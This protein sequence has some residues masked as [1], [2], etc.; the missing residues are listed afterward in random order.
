MEYTPET[1]VQYVK[2]V[3]P[4]FAT[5]L[6]KL[7]IKT[8]GDLLFLLPRRYEDRTSFQKIREARPGQTVC[9]RGR[10]IALDSKK[11][12][13]TMVI[14]R[15][16]IS[17]GSGSIAL[18]WFNQRWIKQRLEKVDGDIIVYGVVK[19]GNYGFEIQSPEFETIEKDESA[20]NF[21]RVTPIYPLTEG[22]SQKP[23]RKAIKN[24]IEHAAKFVDPLPESFLQKYHLCS[25]KDA[26]RFVHFPENLKDVEIGRRRLI[27]EDFFYLQIAMLKRRTEIGLEKGIAFQI[28]KSEPA[29][30]IESKLHF[31]LTS[32]Q[33][34]VINEIFADMR[35][36]HPMN[37]LLQGD[38]G[39]GKTLVAAAAILAA[40]KNGYQCALMA[41]TEILAEQHFF[42]L[43]AIFESLEVRVGLLVGK[44]SAS[45]KRN[46][47]QQIS[48][49]EVSLVVGTHALIQENVEFA[50]LGLVVVDEQHRFG[51]LQ[52]AALRQKGIT[53]DV[54]VMSATP[55][56]RSLT[57]T[58][59][60]DLSLSVIDEMPIGRKPIKTH[61][62]YP[63]ERAA[64]YDGVKKLVDKGAQVYVVCPLVS[65]SEKL[66]VQAAEEL[67][68]RMKCQVF[69]DYSIGLL[70]G[71]QKSKDKQAVMQLFRSG[72]LQILVSTTV[73]EVGVDVPNATVM[74]IEDANRFGLSQLHQLRGRVGRGSS[75]SY[76]VLIASANTQDAEDRLKVMAETTNGFEIAEADLKIRGP[77][78]MLGTRQS[79]A[80][81]FKVADI[82][83]DGKLLEESRQAAL[84]LLKNDPKLQIKD[85]QLIA[86]QANIELTQLVKT[87]LS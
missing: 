37:R 70:H 50:N 43:Q 46:S 24:A 56:P 66:Q 51:V 57:L 39:S 64:V 62:K 30:E 49:S 25:L 61:W 83:R 55:I 75:Q 78:D 31:S 27:F 7:N 26:L 63:S 53:P 35:E 20:E 33:K 4:A 68:Q 81:D 47:L 77:G 79:G 41:P 74:I 28:K 72:E 42:N 85:H 69:Q 17:D 65:E 84:E 21:A 5:K 44:Q 36:P 23:L 48:Q 2:G 76:C 3:G 58:L 87:D 8:V 29:A 15:A 54:L 1:E 13:G 59:Y 6:S 12:R 19:E 82:V 18:T 67:Y 22:V 14:I 52:R 34:R 16:A 10:I 9:L 38:V 71:K 73:I 86:K 11:T 80:L 60:G 32:A 45:E 40:A